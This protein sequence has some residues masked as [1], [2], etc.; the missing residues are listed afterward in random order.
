MT[1]RYYNLIIYCKVTIL[2]D[3]AIIS[4]GKSRSKHLSLQEICKIDRLVCSLF[5][6][7]KNVA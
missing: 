5:H 4:Q 1:S 7:F 6:Y 3:H 2:E